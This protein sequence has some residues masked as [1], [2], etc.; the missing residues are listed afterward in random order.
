MNEALPTERP[1]PAPLAD[2]VAIV[3]GGSS[4]I[5]RETCLALAA[6]GAAVVVV[7]RDRQRT[8]TVVESL[9][10]ACGARD[11]LGL[12]LDVRNEVQM[13][14]MAAATVERFGRIDALICSAAIL[15]P[16]GTGPKT[17]RETGTEE[18]D[19]VLATNLKGV[20]LANRAVAR[21]MVG[22]GR[23]DI[24]NLSS[25]AGL[26]GRA[27]DA[28]Y[29]ASKFALIGLSESLAAE[30]RP[31]GVRVQVLC[32]DATETPIWTQNLPLPK[33]A[34]VIP[35]ERISAVIVHALTLP[36][37]ALLPRLVVMPFRTR[38][39]VGGKGREAGR[40]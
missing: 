13:E 20:F 16:A 25:T 40:S 37:D 23:G 30:L 34:N 11:H 32:P 24:L 1:G 33:P 21:V 27:H 14:R 35:A 6:A 9:M 29:S 2:R 12:V 38:R 5:G 10:T 7:G 8:D 39:G 17:L 19:Q 26:V 4:G 18:W 28:C 15:R 36:G 22:Q 31:R 3:T